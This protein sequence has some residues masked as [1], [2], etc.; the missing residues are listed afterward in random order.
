MPRWYPQP[1]WQ[2]RDCFIFG[3][4]SSLRTFDCALLEDERVIGVNQA[5]RL[6]PKVCD[7][8][9][10]GDKKFLM[11]S[12]VTVRKDVYEGLSMFE[13]PVITNHQ[14]LLRRREVWLKVVK[15]KGDGLHRDAVGHNGNSGAMAINLAILLGAKVIY[16]LGFDMRLDEQGRS[17]WHDHVFDKPNPKVYQLFQRNFENIHKSWVRDFQDVRIVNVSSCTRLTTFPIATFDDFW[18]ARKGAYAGQETSLVGAA[19]S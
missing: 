14:D 3:G 15:R 18:L 2:G 1:V 17:N 11:R 19:Y 8:L 5:W 10:F 9:F 13:N 7:Y 12:H 4:G 6:G 16:L